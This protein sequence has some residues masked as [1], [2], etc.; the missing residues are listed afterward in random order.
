MTAEVAVLNKSA[1]ALAADSMVTVSNGRSQKTFIT[2]K[3]FM[4][5]HCHPVGIMVY[6]GA[7]LLGVPWET[8]VSSYTA[9][10]GAKSFPTIT[11]YAND[12]CSFIR[13]SRTLFPISLQ[14]EFARRA[15]AMLFLA[16]RRHAEKDRKEAI[17]KLGITNALPLE[18]YLAGAV[19][20]FA[21][22][23]ADVPEVKRLP[24]AFRESIRS[25]TT[26][27]VRDAKKMVYGEAKIK[28]TAT[29]SRQLGDLVI[30]S[31]AKGLP[32]S[33]STGVVVAG[34]GN[35][36]LYP[37]VCTYNVYGLAENCLLLRPDAEKSFPDGRQIDLLSGGHTAVIPFAQTDVV[38]TLVE[39]VAR[40]FRRDFEMGVVEFASGC[41]EFVKQA[42]TG[43]TK[44]AKNKLDDEFREFIAQHLLGL[45]N[46]LDS[47]VRKKHVD[48]LL[49]VIDVLPK[50]ELANIAESLV[51]L[52]SIKR[53]MSL[54][55]ETVG[56]PI[57]VAIIS[58][59][60]GFVWIS[61]KD[62]F[63]AHLNGHVAENLHRLH[64]SLK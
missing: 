62:Y 11:E 50:A 42:K 64:E 47:K 15:I 51:E 56:G 4:L 9:E 21:S 58:K 38:E 25:S 60:D 57:D 22:N 14:R 53:K 10:L 63:K 48:P 27:A 7:E 18:K 13:R 61:R 59:T 39:G 34:F 28:L 1:V 44:N 26:T 16:I 8:I 40:Q 3:L 43:L 19:K 20:E 55:L 54:D 6:G 46:E 17:R 12:L 30:E 49:D 35:K 5:S 24:P 45:R 29:V 41:Y 32:H 31:F 2:T 23:L 52:T 36:Q 37:E 33:G